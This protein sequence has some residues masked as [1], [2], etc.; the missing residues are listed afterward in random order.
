MALKFE[1]TASVLGILETNTN[2]LNNRLLSV[3]ADI[4]RLDNAIFS[5]KYPALHP[6]MDNHTWA[7]LHALAEDWRKWFDHVVFLG[8]G[9]SSLGAQLLTNFQLCDRFEKP[10]LHFLDN[11]SATSTQNLLDSLPL[12]KTAFVMTSKSGGTLETLVQS[13]LFIEAFRNKGLTISEHALAITH[14]GPSSLGDLCQQHNV[15]IYPHNPDVPGRFS[16]LNEV[17]LFP[18][19]LAG[20][21]IHDLHNGVKSTLNDF[22]KQLA[23][24]PAALD[25]ALAVLAAEKGKSIHVFMPYG[26]RL[27]LLAPWFVQLWSESLGKGGKGSTPFGAVGST[28][29]HSSLQLL[30]DGPKDKLVTL[31]Q[32]NTVG[33]GLPINGEY[34]K[35]IQQPQLAGKTMGTC[36]YFQAKGTAEAL[37]AN[38]VP[39]RVITMEQVT[40]FALGKLLSHFMLKTVIAGQLWQVNPFDQ[41]AVE[42]SKDRT[43]AYLR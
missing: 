35:A 25:A 23:S 31:I 24:H 28:D 26:N 40:P 4:A 17:G 7:K 37:L 32:P 27:R 10:Y 33:E 29:Q 15:T 12:H 9:G 14:N 30:L 39:T 13:A 34:A 1:D 5:G 36:L 8:I 6:P 42:Q 3:E 11:M 20:M 21:N 38:N 18:A 19:M 16:L 2:T 41:P 43:L 22:H